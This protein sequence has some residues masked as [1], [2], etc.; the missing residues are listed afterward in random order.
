MPTVLLRLAGPLQSWGVKSRFSVRATELAPTKSGVIGLI[1]AAL[2]RQR[3]DPLDDL[4]SLAFGTRT[5]QPGTILRDFHTASE[6]DGGTPVSLSERYYLEDAVFLVGLEGEDSIIRKID[7]ALRRPVFPLYLGRRSCVPAFPLALGIREKAL[8]GAL[9]D[10]PWLASERYKQRH[11]AVKAELRI[12]LEAV[13]SEERRG[14]VSGSRDVPISF[15]PR[16]R[17]YGFREIERLS[18]HLGNESGES[19]ANNHTHASPLEV[20]ERTILS[21]DHDP[22]AAFE[23]A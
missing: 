13:P 3:T 14:Y 6:L 2:G 22:M 18:V 8:L 9:S 20:D 7:E 1:A 21:D 11:P 17:D 5:D 16:Q 4:T 23:E 10:E 19:V 15:D 12:D